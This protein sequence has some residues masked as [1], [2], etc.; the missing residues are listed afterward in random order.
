LK[1]GPST[2]QPE[3]SQGRMRPKSK[4]SADGKAKLNME[5]SLEEVAA[6]QN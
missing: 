5:K 3:S 4:S 1:N 2:D 6:K